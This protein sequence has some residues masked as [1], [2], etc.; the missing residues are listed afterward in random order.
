MQLREENRRIGEFEIDH[1]LIEKACAD[2]THYL[3]ELFM[4]MIILR[5]ESLV[6]KDA[7][8]YTAW[9]R[10]FEPISLND[11]IPFYMFHFF[12]RRDPGSEEEVDKITA[13]R[14]NR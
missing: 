5:C 11:S 3:H 9:S 14:I 8:C 10:F 4:G 12:S 2:P 7:M 1:E 6:Y 13:E